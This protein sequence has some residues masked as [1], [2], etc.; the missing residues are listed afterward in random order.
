MATRSEVRAFITK[1]APIVVNVCNKKSKKILPSVCIAQACCESA[2]GTSTKMIKANAVFGIKVGSKKKYGTAWK[3]KAYNTK[4]KECYD[5]T[6][7]VSIKDYFRAYDSI[8]DSVEDYYDMIGGLSRYKKAIGE[9][10]PKTCITA[11]KEAGYAT[12]P[13]YVNTIM[14]IIKSNGLTAYDK[15]MKNSTSSSNNITSQQTGTLKHKIGEIITV[16]SYYAS[17]TDPISKVIIKKNNGTII[18]VKPG[19]NNP[20]CFGNPRTKVAVGWCNDGDIRSTSLAPSTSSISNSNRTII[21]KVKAGDNLTKI[22]KNYNTTVAKIVSKNKSK[23][24]KITANY[25]VVGW[26]LIVG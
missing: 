12:D 15:Y 13:N 10:D 24:P 4:T 16:S 1:I 23:Y 18:K 8:E 11:I 25:I 26:E 3:G 6:N 20:Y 22:A 19:T 17:S 21:H 5:G 9:L 7:M 2:Y 14:S